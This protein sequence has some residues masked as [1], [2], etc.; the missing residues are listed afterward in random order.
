[1]SFFCNFASLLVSICRFGSWKVLLF[2]AK[3]FVWFLSHLCL[4]CFLLVL[5]FCLVSPWRHLFP[6]LRL[7]FSSS[8]MVSF[9]FGV[10]CIDRPSHRARGRRNGEEIKIISVQRGQGSSGVSGVA[11]LKDIIEHF[12]FSVLTS[13]IRNFFHRFSPPQPLPSFLPDQF[14]L[15]LPLFAPLSRFIL[16]LPMAQ[17]SSSFVIL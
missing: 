10:F 11:A 8:P 3:I 16:T 15:L 1:M 4:P 5:M 9:C 6:F 7:S 13:Q 12:F 2:R 14:A 17:K